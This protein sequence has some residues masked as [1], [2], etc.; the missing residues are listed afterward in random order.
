MTNINSDQPKNL[1]KGLGAL[2][3]ATEQFW[4]RFI[5]PPDSVTDIAARRKAQLSASISILLFIV[6]V[7]GFYAS[8][9]FQEITNPSNIA[10]LVIAIGLEY[11]YL[12]SR[13]KYYSLGSLILVISLAA[14]GYGLRC[15]TQRRVI[16]FSQVV[17]IRQFLY[18]WYSVVFCY[19]CPG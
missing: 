8:S 3:T 5:N 4:G 11:A 2:G 18:L 13:T 14:S 10:L 16:W 6:V 7:I 9:G 1:R 12:I 15:R 19:R 17:F